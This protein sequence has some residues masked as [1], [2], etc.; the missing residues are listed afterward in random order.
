MHL[1]LLDKKQLYD[2]GLNTHSP[3]VVHMGTINE[4]TH[5]TQVLHV[6]S[7]LWDRYIYFFPP[8]TPTEFT[9]YS[10][11]REGVELFCK[12][13][14]CIGCGF[15]VSKGALSLRRDMAVADW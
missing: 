13:P 3:K 14:G 5:R 12:F 2:H 9:R 6:L 7:N 1:N 10:M 4:D 11:R 15:G 8:L